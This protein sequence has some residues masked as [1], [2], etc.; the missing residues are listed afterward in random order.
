M[1]SALPKVAQFP[2]LGRFLP[3][4]HC[5]PLAWKPPPLLSSQHPSQ[6]L[7]VCRPGGVGSALLPLTQPHT[8][9]RT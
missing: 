8:L 3:G 1:D 2:D 7:S 4:S 5:L 6:P 9:P